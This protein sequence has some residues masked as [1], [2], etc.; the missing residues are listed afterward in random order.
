MEPSLRVYAGV[1][2]SQAPTTGAVGD[3]ACSTQCGLRSPAATDEPA[4]RRAHHASRVERGRCTATPRIDDWFWLRD[5]DDPRTLAL[6]EGRER[7]RRRL[8]SLPHRALCERLYAEMF[9]AHPAAALSSV[10]AR[11]PVRPIRT[12]ASRGL[13][14]PA[15]APR[16]WLS[17]RPQLAMVGGPSGGRRG[18]SDRAGPTLQSLLITRTWVM[19]APRT[20]SL[21]AMGGDQGPAVVVPGRRWR[22]SAIPTWLSC[23]SATRSASRPISTRIPQLAERSRIIHTDTRGDAGQAEP[24][25]PPR[26][27][28]QHVAGH[29]GGAEARGRFRGLGRQHRRADGHGQAGPQDHARHRAPRHRRPMADRRPRQHRPRSRRQH[30]RYRPPARRLRADGRRHGARDPS[31]SSARASACSTSASRRSRASR[32]CGRR[33]PGSRRTTCRST[34]AAS[35]RATRSARASSTSSSWKAMPAISRSRPPR[36]RQADGDLRARGADQL[37]RRQARRP[38]APRAACARSRT[39]WI[40]A[41]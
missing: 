1:G 35:S 9:G 11:P 15:A 13:P 6:P 22:S 36:D 27:R 7:L 20:I 24:G 38:A 30:R 40:R 12:L 41:V 5:R 8:G 23:F 2:R 17:V 29:R 32:R 34:I 25:S 37:A 28:L 4:I 39:A 19:V 26:P 10:P 18:V 33:T 3:R 14:T 21:D 31:A 16:I